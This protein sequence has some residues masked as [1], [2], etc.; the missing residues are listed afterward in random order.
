[1]PGKIGILGLPQRVRKGLRDVGEAFAPQGVRILLFGSFAEG[2][3]HRTSDLDLAFAL[4]AAA[5]PELR[6]QL[7]RAIDR[8]PTIRPVDLVDLAT[9]DRSLLQS[10]ES[11]GIP[12]ENIP[13]N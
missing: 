13:E 7:F 12:L 3:A 6:E 11:H 9:A 4:P 8:L 1:M 5:S 2:R 10:A